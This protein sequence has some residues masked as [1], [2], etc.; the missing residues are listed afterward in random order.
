[1]GTQALKVLKALRYSVPVIVWTAKEE[2][3]LVT[4]AHC[5]I[6]DN[7]F[8]YMLDPYKLTYGKRKLKLYHMR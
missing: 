1:M 8:L 5:L 3:S 2:F 4:K 7:S 6:T